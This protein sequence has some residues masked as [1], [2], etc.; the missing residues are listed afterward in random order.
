MYFERVNSSEGSNTPAKLS[1]PLGF[2]PYGVRTSIMGY[3]DDGDESF[4]I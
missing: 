1:T 2:T 3:G 4:G